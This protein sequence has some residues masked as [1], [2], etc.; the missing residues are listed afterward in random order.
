MLHGRPKSNKFRLRVMDYL[1]KVNQ[2]V[3][4]A[5]IE[6][7]REEDGAMGT[8]FQLRTTASKTLIASMTEKELQTLNKGAKDVAQNGYPE[9]QQ[10]RS[11][12]LFPRAR[13]GGKHGARPRCRVF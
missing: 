2:T 10:R 1:W 7:M 13:I 6:R 3:V 12:F 9:N 4:K 8:D 5:E 11:K